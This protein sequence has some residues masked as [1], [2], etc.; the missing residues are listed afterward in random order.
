MLRSSPSPKIS[1]GEALAFYRSPSPTI[2]LATSSF[3]VIAAASQSFAASWQPW[4]TQRSD[5]WHCWVYSTWLT[6]FW[7]RRF[8]TQSTL[9]RVSSLLFGFTVFLRGLLIILIICLRFPRLACRRLL[10]VWRV[11]K[12]SLMR[13]LFLLR[14]YS[15]SYLG[16]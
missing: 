3:L 2:T 16:E 10:H 11:T 7:W 4:D 6:C 14:R 9:L 13:L 15:T 5:S 8:T 1:L 12:K